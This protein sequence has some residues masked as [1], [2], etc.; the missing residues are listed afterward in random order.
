[1]ARRVV[2]GTAKEA[3]ARLRRAKKH[4]T[5][6]TREYTPEL[7]LPVPLVLDEWPWKE[8][9]GHHVNEIYRGMVTRNNKAR[10]RSNQNKRDLEESLDR[11]Y[12]SS[13]DA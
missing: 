5:R 9:Y 13:R 8:F 1:M 4:R 3:Q 2:E 12:R 10:A 6:T 7:G 11:Y